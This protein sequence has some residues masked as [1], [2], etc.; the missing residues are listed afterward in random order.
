MEKGRA[1]LATKTK[2]LKYDNDNNRNPYPIT[3]FLL[4]APILGILVKN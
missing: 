4:E 3:R 1:T 2:V